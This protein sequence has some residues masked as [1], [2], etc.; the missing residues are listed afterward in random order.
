[1]SHFHDVYMYIAKIDIRQTFVWVI[2]I[3]VVL[4]Y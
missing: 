1:M 3:T 2:I 4:L